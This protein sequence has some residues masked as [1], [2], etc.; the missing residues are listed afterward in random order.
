MEEIYISNKL[1][2]IRDNQQLIIQKKWD[3]AQGMA[4]LVFG[5]FWTGI[6]SFISSGFLDIFQNDGNAP[7][8]LKVILIVFSLMP[9]L[10]LLLGLG[11][12][13]TGLAM[14]LN[15]TKIR[16]DSDMIFSQSGPIPLVGQKRLAS[17]SIQQIYVQQQS[18]SS[19]DNNPSNYQLSYLDQHNTSKFLFGKLAFIPISMPSFSLEEAQKL[20]KILED[21]LGIENQAVPMEVGFQDQAKI[22][23]EEIEVSNKGFWQEERPSIPKEEVSNPKEATNKEARSSLLLAYPESLVVEDS[24]DGL[25]ILKKWRSSMVIFFIIFALFWNVGVWGIGSSLI[26]A[27]MSEAEA[28]GLPFLLFLIP[29]LAVG[30]WLIYKCLSMLFNSTHIFITQEEFRMSTRPIPNGR[31]IS[32][33]REEISTIRLREEKRS[34]DNGIYWVYTLEL[35]D[36]RGKTYKIGGRYFINWTEEEAKFLHLKIKDYL[37]LNDET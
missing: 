25:F 6:T 11:I 7:V 28:F 13:Y 31:A 3:K 20:E 14:L 24:S 29:F 30:I 9:L 32:L 19:K 21:F 12:F 15:Q 2:I 8:F 17:S 23:E 4:F 35:I 5:I 10:F 16:V 27:R 18:S 26:G 22:S 1:S 33:P 37:Q 34:R 36:L